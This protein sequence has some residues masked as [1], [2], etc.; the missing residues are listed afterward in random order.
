MGQ[1]APAVEVNEELS[2]EAMVSLLLGSGTDGDT[3]AIVEE[4]VEKPAP[5][6][7]EVTTPDTG[8]VDGD[9]KPVIMAKDGIHTIEYE[10]L[11]KA[12]DKTKMYKENLNTANDQLESQGEE[13][14]ALKETIDA[15]KIVDD[16]P[17]DDEA[18]QKAVESLEALKTNDPEVYL[19]VQA[20]LEAKDKVFV[21]KLAELEDRF[22]NSLE[23]VVE[24]TENIVHDNHFGEI[25]DVHED[26]IELMETG[27]VDAYVKTLP[28]YAQ[29]GA[30][31]VLDNGS[32]SEVIEFVQNYKDS[33]PPVSEADEIAAKAAEVVKDAKAK[34]TVP[35]SLSQVP[36]GSAAHHDENAATL[37]L[38]PMKQ[39]NKYSNMTSSAIL[40]NMS[41]IL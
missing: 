4:S 12:R 11:E 29:A 21:D 14:I 8:Q 32:A 33:L 37:E 1:T 40:A 13:L 35:N 38:S 10:E 16:D 26:F 5:A 2:S 7:T 23:P 39:V 30:N 9:E 17:A 15:L 41:R 22:A 6:A 24:T 3:P 34:V 36:A 25:I 20:M 27:V 19:A 28:G 18:V 31:E